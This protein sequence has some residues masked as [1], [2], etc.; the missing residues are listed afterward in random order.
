[1]AEVSSNGQLPTYAYARST[2]SEPVITHKLIYFLK[3]ERG[4]RRREKRERKLEKEG[5]RRKRRR[6]KEEE[7][8]EER[9]I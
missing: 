2:N 3:G 7:D 8:K 6:R 1:M 4:I 9:R 5:R